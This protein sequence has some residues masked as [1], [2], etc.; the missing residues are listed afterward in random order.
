MSEEDWPSPKFREH[1]I[2]RLEPELARNRQ[3]APNLPVPGDARQVEEYV[4]AKCMSKDEYMRTIAK[5]I[6]AI[7]CNSKSAAVP[8]VLQPSQFHSPPCTTAVLGGTTPVGSTPG[9]RA[10]VPPDPQPTSAQARN[11]PSTVATTQASTTPSSQSTVPA[12]TVSASAAVAAAV[13][14]FPSPDTAIRVGGQT[15]PGSQSSGQ[16]SAPNVPFPNGGP[17]QGSVPM[18][19]GGGPAMGQPPP[20]MGAPNM[21]MGGPP[22]GYGGYGMMNG[23]PGGGPMGSNPYNQQMKKEMEQNR[24]WDPQGHM[25]QQPQWGGM[26]P[27]QGHGYPNRPMNGQQTTPT[28]TSSVLESLINQPQQYPGHH[29]QMGPTGPDRNMPGNRPGGGPGGPQRPGMPVNQAMMSVEDQNVYS[30]KLRNMRGSCE[31][32]R[33]RARQ[34]RQEGNHEAAH[35]LEVMLSVLEGKRVVS[36]E[37]LNHLETWIAR[38]QDFLNINQM[39][40]NPNHMGMNDPVM[41]GDH[42]MMGNGQVHNPYGGHPGYN[43]GQYMGGPPPHMQQ[44]M[45]QSQ[46]MWHQQ[47]QQQRMMQPQDH[48]MMGGGGPMHGMYRGDMGH[49]QMTSPVNNHRH[50]PYQNP[51][52]RNN[53]RQMPNGPGQIGRDRNSMSGS[54]SGPSSGAPS[55]NPMGTPNQKMGTPGSIGGLSGLDDFTYDDFLPNPIDALQPTLHV[56][57]PSN[58]MNSGQPVQRASLTETARK[59]LQALE[60]RFEIDPNHQRHDANHILVSCKLRNQ[61]YPPLRLVVPT[62]YPAGSVTVDRAV[63]DLDAYLYDDLQNVVNERLSRPGLSSLTDYLNAWEEQV[64]QYLQ[65]NQSNMDPS[66]GVSNDFFYENLNL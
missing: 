9:Y 2:Q 6:N 66:F 38:K 57:N 45:H 29:N 64:N 44:Q 19:G 41:N 49:D 30:M 60:A 12:G 26:P 35:K 39:A 36:L 1:V 7:N 62:T 37:Y 61:P 20:Q 22:G 31:S 27:Q 10:P 14:N 50:A 51:A 3:N 13:A 56:G 24:P 21:G 53:M 48:M 42:G 17:Q 16:S 55:M 54:M 65:Q 18:N 4:F 63:I 46:Q 58:S 15:T 25:Y 40:Q 52:M 23:P 47:Q 5:V 28:G 33:T 11:P 43:H 32:L 59:E 8:S 34:C